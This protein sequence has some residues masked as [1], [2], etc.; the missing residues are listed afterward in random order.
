M[1]GIVENRGSFSAPAQWDLTSRP[2][3]ET[4]DAAANAH[5]DDVT[6]NPRTGYSGVQK[7]ESAFH[8]FL[9]YLML[10]LFP[11]LFLPNLYL[12][13]NRLYEQEMIWLVVL[14]IPIALLA[15]DFVSGMVHWA[16][17]TYGSEDMPVLG[18]NFVKPFRLHH[19]YPRDITTHPFAATIG[20][21][22]LMAAPLLLFCLYLMW[23]RDV[24]SWLAFLILCVSL[25]TLATA[26]TNQFHKWAHSENPPAFA[27]P[28]QRLR[29]VLEPAHHELHHTKPF[30]T[31]YCITN[32]WLNS[33]LDG[34][35]FFRGLEGALALLGI[36]TAKVNELRKPQSAASAR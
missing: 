3:A 9:E 35:K 32:G 27:R 26:A 29:L 6:A 5:A 12:S 36:H 21:V 19:I 10:S 7:H 16:A 11:V 22:C 31:H 25:M 14:A 33:L 34:I 30:E 28:L 23:G 24:S 18:P 4:E 2:L 17:D 13:L 15:G 8:S 1:S 20:N